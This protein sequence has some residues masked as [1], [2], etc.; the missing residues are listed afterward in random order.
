MRPASSRRSSASPEF[1]VIRIVRLSWYIVG[2]LL[3]PLVATLVLAAT[4]AAG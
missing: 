4:A 1:P 3:L 2:L